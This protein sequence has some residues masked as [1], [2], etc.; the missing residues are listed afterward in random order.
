M[1]RAPRVDQRPGLPEHGVGVRHRDLGDVCKRAW[2]L[3]ALAGAEIGTASVG[4]GANDEEIGARAFLLVA[5]P[6]GNDDDIARAHRDRLALVSAEAGARL[7]FGDAENL[8]RSAVIV[9]I[10][11]D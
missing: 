6:G 5:A 4:I 7:A 3:V 11:I 2:P 9:M 1:P 8:M 10:R